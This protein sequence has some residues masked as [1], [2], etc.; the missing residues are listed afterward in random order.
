MAFV[1]AVPVYPPLAVVAGLATTLEG[2][3][4]PGV[5]LSV[6]VVGFSPRVVGLSP[7]VVGLSLPVPGLDVAGR[8]QGRSTPQGARLFAELLV[9]DVDRAPASAAPS[10]KP[11][12][13][14]QQIR[15]AGSFAGSRR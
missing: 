8:L 7:P 12:A 2:R 4:S 9:I 15:G 10:K 14:G 1:G 3:S 13:T 5:G 6:P 11:P